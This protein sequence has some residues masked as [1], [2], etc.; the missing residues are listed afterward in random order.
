MADY[1]AAAD[2]VAADIAAGKLRPGERLPPVRE[3]ADRA[4]MAVSTA[5]RVYGELRRRGLVVGEV[6]RGT[7]VKTAAPRPAI[8]PFDA[9]K[10]VINL[11]MNT[12]VLPE[13]AALLAR[14]LAPIIKRLAAL[15]AGLEL[16]S[17][18]GSKAARSAAAAFLAHDDWPVDPGSVCFSGNGKQ[19][20]AAAILATVPVGQRLATD[21]LTYPLVKSV[22]TGLG[23]ELVPLAFDEHGLR[24]DALDATHRKTPLKAIYCQPA[25][26]NPLGTTMPA[27]R[28]ADIVRVLQKRGLIAI[29]DHVYGF[30]DP[31]A[32][33]LASVAPDRA[34]V[35][36]SLSKRVA[37][38]VTLGFV[39]C[40]RAMVTRIAAAVRSGAWTPVGLSMELCLTWMSDGTAAGLV[41]AKRR[42]AVVR[43]RILRTALTGLALHSN[44]LAYHGWLSLPEPWRA[45]RFAAAAAQRGIAVTPAA[46]FAVGPGHA[47]NA[48]RL[49]LSAPPLEE[50]E[51]A[52]QTL[53]A[54]A[55][56]SPAEWNTE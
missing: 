25:L 4:R 10:P 6:G 30:L 38:G 41:A 39:V 21:A 53:A 24:P 40:P 36:D 47:P 44:P 3:F 22:A 37:P 12:C 56:T 28:R 13:Q 1:R 45:E 43:Q 54:L 2:R 20:L 14:S 52:L 51:R 7:Y 46:A 9:V 23:V 33:P 18:L 32:V 5:S 34:I 11:E 17:P 29:E 19:A 48:V 15:A 49:A 31:K 26:H 27:S 16:A 55:R 50:L 8:E 42:D 35:V